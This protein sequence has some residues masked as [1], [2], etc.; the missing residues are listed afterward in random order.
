MGVWEEARDY[1]TVAA[2][3]AK[4]A[5]SSTNP[6]SKVSDGDVIEHICI[7]PA[8]TSP[9]KV[10]IFDGAGG[11]EINVFPGGASSVTT[12]APIW[13]KLNARAKN[14]AANASGPRWLVTTGANVS[15]IAT[16]KFY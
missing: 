5:L 2:S 4:A 13:V 6:A 15:V 16:G 11:T 14:A 3:Q 10:S 12:L 9:G 7:I 8:T 1:A